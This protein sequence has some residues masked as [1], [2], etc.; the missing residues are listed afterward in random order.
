MDV[1]HEGNELGLTTNLIVHHS[2]VNIS[3]HTTE[4]ICILDI[5]KESL[6]LP[7]ICQQNKFFENLF[8]FPNSL[9]LL[10]LGLNFRRC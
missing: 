6:N 7:L 5:G 8:Q 10:G 2:I 4:H 3:N 9:W 1:R